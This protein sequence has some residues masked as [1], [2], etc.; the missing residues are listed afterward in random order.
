MDGSQQG[1]WPFLSQAVLPE[2]SHIVRRITIQEIA[3]TIE[4]SAKHEDWIHS[5]KEKY[6]L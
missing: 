6:G 3:Q 1:L 5:F 2:K 4:E